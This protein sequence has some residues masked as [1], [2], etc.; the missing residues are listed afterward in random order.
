[1]CSINGFN[2]TDKAL[3]LEMMQ[4]TKHRGPD[5][6]G[7]YC[8]EDISLG[9]ARLSIID[10]TEK[11]RQPIWNEDHSICVLCNGEIYNF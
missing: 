6:E 5:Q 11:G 3:I 9:H 4:E 8:G 10:L 7:V 1:M 2:F